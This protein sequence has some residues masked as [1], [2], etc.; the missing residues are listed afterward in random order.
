[1]AMAP[2]LLHLPH[3]RSGTPPID[4]TSND[5]ILPIDLTQEILQRLPTEP[6]CRFRAVCRSWRSMLSHPDFIAAARNPGPLLAAA[7]LENFSKVL[8][9]ESG[10]EVKQVDFA[11]ADGGSS[12]CSLDSKSHERAVCVVGKDRRQISLLDPATG[13]ISVLPDHTQLEGAT[14]WCTI[15]RSASTGEHKVLTIA[16]TS[17]MSSE[18]EACKILTL[19]CT[20]HVWRETASAPMKAA[21][22]RTGFPVVNGV[23]YMLGCLRAGSEFSHRIMEFD[24][25]REAWRPA[26]IRTPRSTWSKRY[27]ITMPHHHHNPLSY[28]VYFEKPLAIL[29]DGRIVMWMRVANMNIHV[30]DDTFLRIYDPRTQTFSDGT[31]IPSCDRATVFTWSLLHTGHEGALDTVA[32]QALIRRRHQ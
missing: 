30:H 12:C 7:V 10:D 14:T 22:T 18:A 2:T 19:S 25:D 3:Q 9:T 13:A 29:D 28:H 32:R 31:R 21:R 20:D 1:M 16:A 15:G 4:A 23:A 24:L 27:T 26:T 8:D 17:T 5:G 6:I 11:A